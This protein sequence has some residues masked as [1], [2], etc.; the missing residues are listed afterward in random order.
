M[1]TCDARAGG[2]QSGPVPWQDPTNTT[3]VRLGAPFRTRPF[4]SLIPQIL[5]AENGRNAS[6]RL[7]T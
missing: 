1:E 5:C 2:E 3:N 7:R 6:I 4:D